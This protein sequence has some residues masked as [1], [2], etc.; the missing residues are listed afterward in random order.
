MGRTL[1]K[2][3]NKKKVQAMWTDLDSAIIGEASRCGMQSV[4]VYDYD[5]IL[6]VYMNRDHMKLKEAVEYVDYNLVNAWIGEGTPLI[7]TRSV[8]YEEEFTGV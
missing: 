7:F 3:V 6:A 1:S 5:K 4:L 8:D 2:S